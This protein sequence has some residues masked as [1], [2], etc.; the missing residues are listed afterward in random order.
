MSVSAS[1]IANRIK[2]N[3]EAITDW[4]IEGMNVVIQDMRF[5]N[6]IAQALFDVLTTDVDVLPLAHSGDDLNNPT[7]QPSS[8][9]DPQ[10]GTVNSTTTAPQTIEGKG[11]L[12]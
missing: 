10:G 1:G 2:T 4:P 5:I 11:R 3:L 6:A 9:A 8:G 7:G 12:A